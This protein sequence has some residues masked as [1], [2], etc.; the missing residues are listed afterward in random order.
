MISFIFP[1]QGSQYVGMGKDLYENYACARKVFDSANRILGFS[2]TDLCFNGPEELLSQTENAQPAILTTSIASL[3]VLRE[4]LKQQLDVKIT[5]SYVAGLSLGEYTA[6]FVAGVLKLEDAV[7][8]VRKRGMYMKEAAKSNPGKMLS[9]IGLSQEDVQ[10]TCSNSNCEI[11]N[12]NCP[13][14][15]VIS[16]SPENI[17]RAADLASKKGAKRTIV[18]KVSGA[19]HCSLMDPAK[20]KLAKEMEQVSFNSPSMEVVSNVTK[21]GHSNIEE[22]RQNLIKQVSSSTYWED[23]IKF[24]VSKGVDVFLEIGPGTVLKGLNRRIDSNVKTINLGNTDQISSFVTRDNLQ[25]L[26]C[27]IN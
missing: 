5:P 11:A 24:M 16:G 26:N 22:I 9:I 23:S 14:Q 12:L 20:E 3:E 19:F 4:V 21:R 7:M 13:G 2:I 15:V 1:G 18:L 17:Q 27:F 6:L 10:D 25:S 8:L